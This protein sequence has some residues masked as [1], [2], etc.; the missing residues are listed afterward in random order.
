M[1]LS[2]VLAYKINKRLKLHNMASIRQKVFVLEFFIQM[3]LGVRMATSLVEIVNERS[4]YKVI[5]TVMAFSFTLSELVPLSLV[6]YGIY[7]QI[8]W[9]K[10]TSSRDNP[11]AS[12]TRSLQSV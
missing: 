11:L 9:T 1:S 3:I 12:S 10:V 6:V 8:D 5:I 7:L 4:E 2:G